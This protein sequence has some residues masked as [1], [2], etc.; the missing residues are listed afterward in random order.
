MSSR[1]I[2]PYDLSKPGQVLEFAQELKKHIKDNEL[3]TKIKGKDYVLC[4]GWQFA[5]SQ[6]GILSII[7]NVHRMEDKQYIKYWCEVRLVKMGSDEIVGKGFAM[8]SNQEQS[9]KYFDE[10]A[11]CSM[12]Q[13][14]AIAK[15]FRGTIGWLIKASGFEPTPAEESAEMSANE[16]KFLKLEDEINACQT[17]TEL[18]EYWNGLKKDVQADITIQATVRRRKEELNGSK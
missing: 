10:Y 4:E 2:Q 7:E 5:G 8:C 12:A 9:K 14:R 6:L 13:T 11:I 18:E 17:E 3:S 16:E 15:A 1:E